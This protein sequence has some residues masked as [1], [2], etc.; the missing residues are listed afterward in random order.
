MSSDLNSKKS[1]F[2]EF[3]PSDKAEWEELIKQDLN[4]ADYQQKLAWKTLEGITIPPF[5]M[6]TDSERLEPAYSPPLHK[7][8]H[9]ACCEPI[10]DAKP[11][12]ASK[13]IQKAIRGGAD[14]ALISTTIAPPSDELSG[15]ISGT[16]IQTQQN[17]DTLLDG[18]DSG[19]ELI[20]DCGMAA[21]AL[22][23]MM[24]NTKKHQLKCYFTFDPFTF[25]ARHGRLPVPE[26]RISKLIQSLCE[27]VDSHSLCADASFYHHSGATILQ[28][29]AVA[30]AIGSE[31]L[32]SVP[33]P[34]RSKTAENLFVK[35]ASGPFFFPEM[36]KF[37]ALRLLWNRMLD[38]WNITPAEPLKIFA[39]TSRVNK[40]AAD[41]HN[42]L[43]RTVNESMSAILGGTDLLMVHPW[44][45]EIEQSS[46]LSKRMARNV[47]HI[48]REEAHF[49][50]VDD[51]A[52][53]SYYVEHLTET[54]ALE[55]WNYFRQIEGE[56]GL[57]QAL[58]NGSVQ[59]EI[60]KAR[61]EKET[62][63]QK[64]ERVLVGSNK[65]SN[66]QNKVPEKPLNSVKTNSLNQTGYPFIPDIGDEVVLLQQ[67]FREGAVIG[68]VL[69]R[70]LEHQKILFT[71]LQEY[72]TAS[73]FEQAR[74]KTKRQ[75]S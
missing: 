75:D 46:E 73:P 47:H 61:K 42:N 74:E 25:I 26:E 10:Y 65:Y 29:L 55:A 22:L 31:F 57:L 13:S 49:D 50:K 52:A 39:E 8:T 64:N 60:I 37:R 51:P 48:L 30:L 20:F 9:W 38:A 12:P 21:P 56:G 34:D 40:S 44:D 17:M 41:P 68:D 28:E 24:K 72:K 14:A 23:S 5:F 70:F 59:N 7:T 16:L 45:S 71:A 27:S 4:G 53:G 67:A 62:A 36:A 2:S 35:M 54:L 66:P 19:T 43:L 3:S 15:D 1:L 11:E 6:K 32:A 63:Y 69:E 33:E 18:M 58:K